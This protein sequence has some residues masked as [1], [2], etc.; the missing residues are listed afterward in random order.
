MPNRNARRSL[1][2]LVLTLLVV[3]LCL[4]LSWWQWQRAGEKREWLADQAEKARKLQ[5]RSPPVRGSAL[6]S[7]TLVTEAT[8]RSVRPWLTPT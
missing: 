5:N 8:T 7:A 1:L 3:G 2:G 4:S 6:L